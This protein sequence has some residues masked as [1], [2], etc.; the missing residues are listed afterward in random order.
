[1]TSRFA[2]QC[3]PLFTI[4][5]ALPHAHAQDAQRA[6]GAEAPA[7]EEVIVTA[8]KRE[9]SLQETPISVAAFSADV[10]EQRQATTIADI[11]RLTPN[12]SMESTSNNGGMSNSTNVFIRGVGQTDFTLTVDP[13][14]GIYLDGVYIS[15]SVGSLLDTADIKRVEVLR[16]PQGTLFGKNTIGGAL[17]VTSAPPGEAL[18]GAFELTTGDYDRADVRGVISGP[19]TDEAGMRAAVSYQSRDGYVR[20]LADGQTLGNKDSLSGRWMTQYR[21]G[22]WV[23]GLAVDAT[24]AREEASPVI[25]LRANESSMFAGFHNFVVNAASCAPPPSPAVPQ[26][27]NAQWVTGDPYSTWATGVNYSDLDLW[28]AAFTAEHGGS[29]DIKS[30]TAYRDLQA[31]YGYDNDASPLRIGEAAGSRYQQNQASQELQ[32]SGDAFDDRLQYILGVFYLK[33][34]GTFRNQL[35]FS[36]ADFISGGAIENDSYAVFSQLTY[37]LGERLNVTLGGRYTH[38]KKRF[39]PDQYIVADRTGGS[40]HALSCRNIPTNNPDCILVLPTAEVATTAEEFTPAVTFDFEVAPDVLAYVNYSKGFKSGGFTQRVFPPLPQAPSFDPEFLESYELGLKSELFDRRLRL[41]LAGFYSD[42]SGIQL[43][44]NRGIAPTVQNAGEARI[45]GFELEYEAVVTDRFSMSGGVG[46]TDAEYRS[47]SPGA[48]TPRGPNN[49]GVQSDNELPN[50]VQWTATSG[51]SLD[52]FDTARGRLSVRGDWFYKSGRYLDAINSPDMYQD[53]YDLVSASLTFV[54]TDD[55]WSISGGATNL[56][57]STYLLSGYQ[58]LDAI[59]GATG[60]FCRPRE[61][62]AKVRMRF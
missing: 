60:T 52:L 54:T 47:V 62:F 38:E 3:L 22:N 44:V 5:V 23:F 51:A 7:L 27:Y 21:P 29:I 33:E 31:D 45:V 57:N 25:L 61:W 2:R 8:R 18:E 34:E 19:I 56:T 24:R 17:V 39:V 43:L 4:V 32:F 1:M 46:H 49:P 35:S 36:I 40:M 28:G 37:A 13:G 12:L 16:G 26:C 53:A 42:Y 14:V 48:A 10:L 58:D 30:I 6:A 59:G 55:R 50:A 41:N 15:R 11:G 9:E 20:R